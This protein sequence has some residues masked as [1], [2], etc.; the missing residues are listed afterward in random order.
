MSENKKYE[1]LNSVEKNE[2]INLS[3]NRASFGRK[4]FIGTFLGLGF[5]LV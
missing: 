1:K 2:D 5:Y 4:F 3:N